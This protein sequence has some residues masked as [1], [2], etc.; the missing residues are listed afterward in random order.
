MAESRY[1][2]GGAPG[3]QVGDL[4]LPGRPNFVDGCAV[5]DAHRAGQSHAFDPL[6]QHTDRVYITTDREYARFYASKYPK[7]DLYTVVPVGE[8]TLSS[9]DHFPSWHVAQ[10][11]VVS[12]YDRYVTLTAKQRRTLLNR[13]K[14]ADD[15]VWLSSVAGGAS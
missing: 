8:L 2:H 7:G 5:C 4:I 10:A 9:E 3:L 14:R 6:T 13:W 12:V 1:W 15:Q 11:R